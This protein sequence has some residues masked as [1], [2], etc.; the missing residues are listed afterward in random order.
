MILFFLGWVLLPGSSATSQEI[1]QSP[2]WYYL[3]GMEL[4]RQG[5]AGE[6]LRH[7]MTATRDP[8]TSFYAARQVALMGE[9]ALPALYRGLWHDEEVI[10][11]MSAVIIG[12]I[13]EQES[14]EA[15]LLRMRFPDAPLETEYAIRKIGSMTGEQILSLVGRQD[16]SNAKLLDRKI[17]TVSR[18]ADSL[19]LPIDPVPLLSLA[20][21]IEQTRSRELEE[22][23]FGHMA[24]A[25]L[26]LLRFLAGRRVSKSVPLLVRALHPDAVEANVA[27][28]RALIGLGDVALE[29]LERSFRES[30]N[31]ALRPYLALA[32]YFASGTPELSASRPISVVMNDVAANPALGLKVATLTALFS[33]APNPLLAWF[34]HHPNAEVRIA[35]APEISA[36]QIRR[37]VELKTFY[38]DKTRDT[39][40]SVAA[41]YFP[42]IANYLPD[43]DVESRLAGVLDSRDEL[44]VLREAALEAAARDGP[45]RLLRGVLSNPDDPLR[46]KAVELAAR[47]T[48]P[49]VITAVLAMLRETDPSEAK[50]AAI[51]VAAVEWGRSEAVPPLVEM[52]RVGDSLWR[53]AAR[54]LAA[55]GSDEAVEP[56]VALIDSGRTIDPD[57]AG[58]LYFA[59][60]GVASRLS[61]SGPG[62]Y[63]FLPLG[64]DPRPAG[65]KVLV[66]LQEKSDYQGWVKAEE[67]WN[68]RRQFRLDEGRG[69]L[70]LYDQ[71]TYDRVASGAGVVL[72]EDSVRQKVLSPLELSELREQKVTVIDDLP[73]RPFAGLD[74]DRLHMLHQGQWTDVALGRDLRDESGRSGWGRSALVPLGF[75]ERD[76]IRFSS[77]PLPSG[78]HKDEPRPKQPERP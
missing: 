47:R 26:S 63:Q 14:M 16:L 69:E 54:G 41:A 7:L 40:T 53:E 70:T 76:R 68:G 13:G 49:E 52:V 66:I 50:R 37:R 28:T 27:I 77:E 22:D 33:E 32:H 43:A 38:L 51:N 6:A 62:S 36:E 24:S 12:W 1:Q 48:E 56:F 57:E 55:L 9:Y 58:A 75:F 64:L 71:D 46:A 18:L 30:D 3:K 42:F 4:W 25:R 60:T 8:E 23:P 74:G 31:E 73:E 10:Q 78:W 34:E 35:L 11:K 39:D 61:G 45:A 29:T 19:R 20:E 67:R 59:F 65:D 72:L 5:Q 17:S 21:A 15:L 44:A 2:R